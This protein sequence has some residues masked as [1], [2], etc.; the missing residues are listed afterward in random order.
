[1][2][3]NQRGAILDRAVR[4][5]TTSVVM[6]RIRYRLEQFAAHDGGSAG[7]SDAASVPEAAP[8]STTADPPASPDH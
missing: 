4:H 8:A 3:F 5:G 2:L 6:C 7:A 1:V